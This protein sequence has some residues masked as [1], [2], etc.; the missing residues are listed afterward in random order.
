MEFKK[1]HRRMFSDDKDKDSLDSLNS[2]DGDTTSSNSV[3]HKGDEIPPNRVIF[4][5]VK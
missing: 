4:Q 5:T 1:A 2:K 3:S